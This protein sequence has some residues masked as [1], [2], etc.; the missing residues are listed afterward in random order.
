MSDQVRT[1]HPRVDQA[2]WSKVCAVPGVTLDH[3]SLEDDFGRTYLTVGIDGWSPSLHE[4]AMEW[5]VELPSA[6][7]PLTPQE[8][9]DHHI[10]TV[11]TGIS[12]LVHDQHILSAAGLAIGHAR[13]LRR[14]GNTTD[15]V[16][17]LH[18]DASTLG[19]LI[20]SGEPSGR[21]PADIVRRDIAGSV[22]KIHRTAI[23]HRGGPRLSD[24]S[25]AVER[26]D[27]RS[28][29]IVRLDLPGPSGSQVR[30]VAHGTELLLNVDPIPETVA[31]HAAGQP[32]HRLV[33]IDPLLDDRI[34]SVVDVRDES[35][36]II[37][38][39]C[40]VAIRDVLAL[41]ANEA[42]EEIHRRISSSL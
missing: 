31:A 22:A 21:T 33:R 12:P 13:P 6:G 7:R 5:R 9:T 14:D 28:L 29:A 42:I 17:H 39:P 18:I 30:C 23:D 27:G 40:E 34:I 1:V 24:A 11:L 25:C 37:L 15:E 16:A 8:I 4:L 26:R 20:A 19:I 32:L 2:V 41:G 38:R 10:Q 36:L 35:T 3:V